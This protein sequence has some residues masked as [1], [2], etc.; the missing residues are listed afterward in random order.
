MKYSQLIGIVAAAG[1]IV[2]CFLPWSYIT[3]Q[4]LVISGLH[5]T[6]T[7]FGKPG[8]MNMILAVVSVIFFL[9]P[10]IW[11]KRTNLFIAA[12][13]LAWSIRNYLLV[14]SCMMGECPEKRPGI[15]LLLLCAIVVQL[16]TFFPKIELKQKD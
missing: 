7:S 6:G 9:L 15:F 16:M 11:A 2:A 5:T 1:I 12:L 8:M 4:Q 14:T 13:G 10:K 3:S